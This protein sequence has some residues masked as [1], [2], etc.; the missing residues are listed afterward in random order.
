MKERSRG[1]QEALVLLLLFGFAIICCA[2]E[3]P[4]WSSLDT[5]INSAMKEWKVPGAAVAIVQ[6]QSVGIRREGVGEK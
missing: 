3:K 2:Q 1:L 6:D 5:S 4:D